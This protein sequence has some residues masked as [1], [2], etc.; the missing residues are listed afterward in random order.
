MKLRKILSLVLV[1]CLC[2]SVFPT[3]VFATDSEGPD[4]ETIED[5]YSVE[6][7]VDASLDEDSVTGY[8]GAGKPPVRRT[9]NHES[10]IMETAF[11][12]IMTEPAALCRERLLT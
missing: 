4:P 11:N 9:G 3:A 6:T 7:V 10:G 8:T 5:G 2:L 1:L 12:S